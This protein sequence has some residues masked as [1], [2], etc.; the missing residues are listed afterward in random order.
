MQRQLN[1]WTRRR[2]DRALTIIAE[3]D[4]QCK[5]T[6]LPERAICGQTLMRIAQAANAA[7]R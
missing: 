2:L 7:R 4:R 5:T 6:G 1:L 3:A